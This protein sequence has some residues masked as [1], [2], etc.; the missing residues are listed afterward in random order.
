MPECL[1]GLQR[2]VTRAPPRGYRGMGFGGGG[3]QDT[4]RTEGMQFIYQAVS[5]LP[6][7]LSVFMPPEPQ[8]RLGQR[9]PQLVW[10]VT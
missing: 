1:A 4:L 2:L 3:G 10:S 6:L 5:V 9:C 7:G 8:C